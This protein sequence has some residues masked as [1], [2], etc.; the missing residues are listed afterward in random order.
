MVK[1]IDQVYILLLIYILFTFLLIYLFTFKKIFISIILGYLIIIFLKNIKNISK[2]IYNFLFQKRKIIFL[3]VIIFFVLIILFIIFL[4][5]FFIFF[6]YFIEILN[7][8][9][10]NQI[11]NIITAKLI[12]IVLENEDDPIKYEFL[13]NI[14]K[15]VL[16]QSHFFIITIQEQISDIISI[17]LTSSLTLPF[18]LYFYLNNKFSYFFSF[19]NKIKINEKKSLI[20]IFQKIFNYLYIFTTAKTLEFLITFLLLNIS[21]YFLE[22]PYL[23]LFCLYFSLWSIIIPYFG[24]IIGLIP[25]VF[26]FY[27]YSFEILFFLLLILFEFQIFNYFF[28]KYIFQKKLNI[29]FLIIQILIISTWKIIGFNYILFS[30][31]IFLI[32]KILFKE[33]IE[34]K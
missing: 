3:R 11:T 20:N 30:I 25:I 29:N 33:I 15:Y 7:I 22:I 28:N 17:I 4:I 14:I 32:Y 8:T 23:V 27:M 31:P 34:V 13:K 16:D 18:I 21:F 5:R 19:L 2:F 24:M 26:I 12:E 1:N 6:K 9:S 10:I